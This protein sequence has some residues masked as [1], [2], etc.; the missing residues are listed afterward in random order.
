MNTMPF[1]TAW[2]FRNPHFQTI[3]PALFRSVPQADY[4]R[5]RIEL[6]DGDFIDIDWCG[7]NQPDRPVTILLHGLEGSSDSQYIRGL[8]SLFSKLGWRTAAINFR[9]CSGETNR[10][11]RSYH[12]GATADLNEVVDFISKWQPETPLHAVGFSLGGNLLLKWCAEKGHQCPLDTAVAVS[13]PYD[14]SIASKTLD[15]KKGIASVYRMRLLQSLKQKA[16][17]KVRNGLIEQ[18]ASAIHDIRKLA[19]FDQQLTA[20]LHGFESA[21]DYY[22]RSSCSPHLAKITIPTLLIHASDDPFMDNHGIPSA[23]DLSA[24]TQLELYP[25]GGHVGFF[26]PSFRGSSYWLEARISEYLASNMKQKK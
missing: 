21:D 17:Y 24:S 4:Q 12:S 26:Q 2:W 10:L 1:K 9:G 5:Q 8:A 6:R 18:D 13:V 19:E 7:K 25:H 3:W 20:P 23:T 14:L 16:L 22:S 11:A 15:D